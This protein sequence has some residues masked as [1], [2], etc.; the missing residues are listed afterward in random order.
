MK[1]KAESFIQKKQNRRTFLKA[2]GVG[3]SSVCL[4]GCKPRG[5][6]KSNPCAKN[7]HSNNKKPNILFIF[8]D[9][10]GADEC[11]IY[12]GKNILTPNID[13]L[14]RDGMM[15]TNGTSTCPLCLPARGMLMTG[16]YPTHTG[17]I[18]NIV[19]PIPGQPCLGRH[20]KDAGYSTGYIGKFHMTAWQ[21]NPAGHPNFIPPGE[22][23]LG[24]DH[25]EA[26]N[27]HLK[28]QPGSYFFYRD[29]SVPIVSDKY[30]T[31]TQTDQAITFMEKNRDSGSPF[32]LVVAPHPPHHPND[33][34]DTPC[35]Y[36]DR[37]PKDLEYNPNIERDFLPNPGPGKRDWHLETRGYLA[38]TK[39]VDDNVGRLMHYL[40]RTGLAEDTIVIFTSDHGDMRGAHGCVGKQH[41][42][43]EG[44]QVPFII[45]WPN[46]IPTGEKSE[47]LISLMDMLPTL[48]AL[49]GQPVPDNLD[50]RNLSKVVLGN[51]KDVGRD[52]L[53]LG[54]YQAD[55][56]FF[57][58][59]RA[60]LTTDYCYAKWID[61][62]ECL[63]SNLNDP[64]Q[65]NNLVEDAKYHSVLKDMRKRLTRL[66]NEAHD[67]F[68]PGDKYK[69]WYDE[70]K[71][72]VRTG[73]GPVKG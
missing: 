33:P 64:Y 67:E 72:V 13:Q 16:R 17:L 69:T 19:E 20:F 31:D 47:T 7:H 52:E 73:R 61:G 3:L 18:N 68:L 57:K 54:F 5:L 35:G 46:N 23:R 42:Y 53:L 12:G 6:K 62:T 1:K 14:A 26:N 55:Y 21:C 38:Q 29:E 40:E 49:T 2:A 50:G 22:R 34:E 43:R 27:S 70:M 48:C 28:F 9:Q 56:D 59:W 15:F 36:L 71:R 11:S 44:Y 25:W 58:E 65:M 10:L 32:F 8:P 4:A 41:P 60:V 30:E 39:N 66:L 45:R 63:T 24:F 37:I 51:K